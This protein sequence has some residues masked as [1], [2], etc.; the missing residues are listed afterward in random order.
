MAD[1]LSALDDTLHMLQWL[2]DDPLPTLR[3]EFETWLCEQVPGTEVRDLRVESEPQWLTG[4]RRLEEDPEKIRL[5][6]TGVAFSFS[7]IARDPEGQDHP[8]RGVF[9]WVGWDLDT[10]EPRTRLWFE[11]DGE[12]E[13]LG[14]EGALMERIYQ[15]S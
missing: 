6:R 14:R 12:L 4:G 2:D 5:V 1:D 9:S 3:R 11:L 8:L 10:P 13:D 7:L 15:E